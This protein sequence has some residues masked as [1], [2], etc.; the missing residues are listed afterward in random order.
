MEQIEL[1]RREYLWLPMMAHEGEKTLDA[2]ATEHFGR[3]YVGQQ[4][5]EMIANDT[6]LVW[7]LSDEGML[8]EVMW[9]DALESKLENWLSLEMGGPLTSVDYRFTDGELGPVVEEKGTV[10][11]DFEIYREAPEPEWMLAKLISLGVLPYG[12]YLVSVWW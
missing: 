6:Y 8:A 7:D 10:R 9:D 12:V 4:T 5:G 1:E 2:I 3:K 11:Y